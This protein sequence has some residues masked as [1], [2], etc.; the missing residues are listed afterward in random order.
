VI[1]FIYLRSESEMADTVSGI[2]TF[3]ERYKKVL[4]ITYSFCQIF[5][6]K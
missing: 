6:E 4:Y 1:S 2:K 5:K 3:G